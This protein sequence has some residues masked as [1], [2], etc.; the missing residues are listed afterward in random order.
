M[1]ETADHPL[2]EALRLEPVAPGVTRGHTTAAYWNMAGPFGGTTGAA[3]LKAV[4]D[5]PRRRGRPAA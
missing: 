4:L 5:H 2:D 3:M 1:G